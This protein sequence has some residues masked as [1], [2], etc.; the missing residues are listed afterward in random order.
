MERTDHTLTVTVP[1]DLPTGSRRAVARY[2]VTR[3]LLEEAREVFH[4]RHVAAARR[5]GRSAERVIIKDMSSRWGSCGPDGNLSLNWRLVLAPPRVIDYV[6]VHEL[7][8]IFVPNHS[9]AF[10]RRVAGAC[11]HWRESREWLRLHGDDLDL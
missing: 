11:E 9:R 3:W 7:S 4:R 1:P 2:A 5:V 6:M 8:H 10:W